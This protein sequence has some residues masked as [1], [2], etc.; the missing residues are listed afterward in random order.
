MSNVMSA[1]TAPAS[2]ASASSTAFAM[3]RRASSMRSCALPC[4]RRPVP[5][6]PPSGFDSSQPR[7]VAHHFENVRASASALR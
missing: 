3:Q 2:P 7:F 1:A 4:L 5:S 6:T